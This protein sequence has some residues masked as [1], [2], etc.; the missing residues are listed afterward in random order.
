M[1]RKLIFPLIILVYVFLLNNIY[2]SKNLSAGKEVY[3]SSTNTGSDPNNVVDGTSTCWQSSPDKPTPQYIY[4]DLENVVHLDN[5]KIFW[6]KTANGDPTKEERKYVAENFCVY[7]STDAIH[8]DVLKKVDYN[9]FERPHVS[10][11][12][13]PYYK[14]TFYTNNS[15]DNIYCRYLLIYATRP[16]HYDYLPYYNIETGYK[17]YEVQVFGHA[18]KI[19]DGDI[20]DSTSI[21]P[22]NSSENWKQYVGGNNASADFTIVDKEI[23]IAI[24][25]CGAAPRDVILFQDNITITQGKTYTLSFEARAS[26][27]RSTHIYIG[28][29]STIADQY[30]DEA[31]ATINLSSTMKQETITFTMNDETDSAAMLEF[32]FGKIGNCPTA[33]NVYL[34]N[35]VLYEHD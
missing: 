24:A 6:W 16:G 33:M 26:I 4:V 8:W 21:G 12:P 2:A 29:Y 25:N 10:T 13:Q 3:A 34:D 30:N 18:N 31:S 7:Y 14:T 22:Y 20:S 32:D 19:V 5:T 17:L 15:P 1:K 23:E 27:P 9:S 11:T 28:K 35:I